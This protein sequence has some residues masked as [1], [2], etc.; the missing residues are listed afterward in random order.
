MSRKVRPPDG[1]RHT[2]DESYNDEVQR[3]VLAAY[4][5]DVVESSERNPIVKP[6]KKH[7]KQLQYDQNDLDMRA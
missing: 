5:R 3:R 6:E 2:L 7:L 4:R 1:E